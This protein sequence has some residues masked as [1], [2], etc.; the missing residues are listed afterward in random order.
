MTF[1]MLIQPQL[2][3]PFIPFPRGREIIFKGGARAEALAC[4]GLAPFP[5][6]L[7]INR[8]L[9]FPEGHSTLRQ[10]MYRIKAVV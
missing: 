3:I 10:Q 4:P 5:L 9:S 2:P 7:F 1:T 8:F 6:P